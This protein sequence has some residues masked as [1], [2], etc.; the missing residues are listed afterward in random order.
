[1]RNVVLQ[2]GQ[3]GRLSAPLA[4]SPIVHQEEGLVVAVQ[5]AGVLGS[6]LD[7]V[8][9]WETSLENKYRNTHK[10]TNCVLGDTSNCS[11]FE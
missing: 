10:W 7:I 8:A 3:E 11:V 5:A 4:Y 1:M 2:I 9:S 6:V